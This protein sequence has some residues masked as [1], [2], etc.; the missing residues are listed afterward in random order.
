MA[1]ELRNATKE[2]LVENMRAASAN[3]E[4]KVRTEQ[5]DVQEAQTER[6]NLE[7][8]LREAQAAE[9]QKEKEREEG[10][11]IERQ[12]EQVTGG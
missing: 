2:N 12:I 9:Q 8:E 1:G 11:N 5:L 3:A 7:Q 4:L 10:E 6:L